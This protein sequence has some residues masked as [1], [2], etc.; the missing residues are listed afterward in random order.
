MPVGRKVCL[1]SAT[2][3]H[4]LIIEECGLKIIIPAEVI[5]PVVSEYEVAAQGLWGGN[6]EFPE[7]SKLIS[8][9]C[10]IS[11]SSS[12]PLN[13]PV[14]IEL[15]HC[16][17][18]VNERQTKYLHFVVAKSGPPFKF[19]FVRGG[20]FSSESCIGRISLKTFSCLAIVNIMDT[21]TANDVVGGIIGSM[22]GS[23]VGNMSGATVWFP[24]IGVLI[25]GVIGYKVGRK[26][27]QVRYKINYGFF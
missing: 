22:V 5:V 16:A 13:K 9:V 19:K 1:Y 2:T 11:I 25:G 23:M 17:Y 4:E 10:Y 21:F 6:F 3:D 26:L 24:T 8:G 15:E 20:S 14:T 18:I 27:I 7:C 12:S